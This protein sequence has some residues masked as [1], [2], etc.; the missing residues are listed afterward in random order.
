MCITGGVAQRNRRINSPHTSSPAWGEII[1][2]V[3]DNLVLAG[4]WWGWHF[5]SAGYAALHLR[6]CTSRPCG[7][8]KK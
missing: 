3:I 6:L 7:T 4:L 8:N 2:A 5:R 1:V